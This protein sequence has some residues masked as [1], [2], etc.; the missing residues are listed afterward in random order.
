MEKARVIP[1]DQSVDLRGE[2]SAMSVDNHRR[3]VRNFTEFGRD[4]AS[5]L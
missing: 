3:E 2:V 4:M 1:I 5:S